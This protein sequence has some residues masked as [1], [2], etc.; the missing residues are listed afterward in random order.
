MHQL[1]KDALA[2]LV[3]LSLI[4]MTFTAAIHFQPMAEAAAREARQA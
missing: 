1:T 3:A 2:G 4:G